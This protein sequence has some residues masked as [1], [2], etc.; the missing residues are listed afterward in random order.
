[1]LDRFLS[2]LDDK[3]GIEVNQLK[4]VLSVDGAAAPFIAQLKHLKKTSQNKGMWRFIDIK[5][6][7]MK[8]KDINMGIIKSAVAYGVLTILNEG[9]L[10]WNKD[11]NKLY[12]TEFFA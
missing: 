11:E 8:K 4:T 6:F 12:V 2:F 9:S 7:T 10:M 3:Y 1:M 5:G